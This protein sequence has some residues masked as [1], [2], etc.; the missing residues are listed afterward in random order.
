LSTPRHFRFSLL[1]LA[2]PAFIQSADDLSRLPCGNWTLVK[3]RIQ[4]NRLKRDF[5]KWRRT[6]HILPAQLPFIPASNCQILPC[7]FFHRVGCTP[8]DGNVQRSPLLT[9]AKA[10]MIAAAAR[11][12]GNTTRPGEAPFQTTAGGQYPQWQCVDRK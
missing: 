9:R 5:H 3:L 1:V 2:A 4:R 12:P 8:S 7:G 6:Q 11:A 10:G